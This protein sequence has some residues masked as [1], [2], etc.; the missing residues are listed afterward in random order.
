MPSEKRAS[1]SQPE[2]VYSCSLLPTLPNSASGELDDC[3]VARL[4]FCRLTRPC[5]SM[6]GRLEAF[7]RAGCVATQPA[8]LAGSVCGVLLAANL[9]NC[10]AFFQSVADWIFCASNRATRSASSREWKYALCPPLAAYRVFRHPPVFH[11]RP[12]PRGFLGPGSSGAL[13]GPASRSP[14]R[15]FRRKSWHLASYR[16]RPLPTPSPIE[17]ESKPVSKL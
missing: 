15:G 7:A 14:N 13:A 5:T 10:R 4:V 1:A 11:R 2:L 8:L 6:D 3:A 17:R 9:S 12:G 16:V